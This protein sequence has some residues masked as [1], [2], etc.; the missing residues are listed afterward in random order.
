MRC[1]GLKNGRE[2]G[3]SFEGVEGGGGVFDGL[4]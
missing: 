1:E 2:L 4:F 3:M